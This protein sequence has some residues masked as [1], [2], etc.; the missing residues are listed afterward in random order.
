MATK[1]ERFLAN[2]LLSLIDALQKSK[3]KIELPHDIEQMVASLMAITEEEETLPKTVGKVYTYTG[4]EF[5]TMGQEERDKYDLCEFTVSKDGDVILRVYWNNT[6]EWICQ[7]MPDGSFV[8]CNYHKFPKIAGAR[9]YLKD[10]AERELKEP[11]AFAKK[12]Y[13]TMP[14]VI[15]R[16]KE[17]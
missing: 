4:I 3:A 15:V 12:F 17:A 14:T 9:G 8:P 7:P 10:L 11:G 16:K 1:N 5:L 2:S 6:L 13:K